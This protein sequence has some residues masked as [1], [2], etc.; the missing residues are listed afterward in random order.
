MEKLERHYDTQARRGLVLTVDEMAAFCRK[1]SIPYSWKDLREMRYRLRYTAFFSEQRRPAQYMGA[2]VEK[3]GQLM[4]DMAFYAPK[5][6][7][8]ASMR[9]AN[10]GF[11]C[12]LV[13]VETLSGKLGAVPCKDSR[14]SS[15]E[16]AI[17]RMLETHFEQVS[18]I[19]SDRDVSVTG[20]AFRARMKRNYGISWTFLRSRSKAYRPERM[21]K[22]LKTRMSLALKASGE[23]RWVDLLPVIV[24]DY[25]SKPIPGTGGI[26]RNSVSKGNYVSML[27]RLYQSEDPGSLNNIA[28]SANY[29]KRVARS[30][31]KF[32][33]G[34]LV[35]LAKSVDYSRKKKGAFDKKSVKGS[36]GSRVYEITG[37]RLKSNGKH[38]LVAVYSVGG[39]SGLYYPGELR[40]A[41]FA[42]RPTPPAAPTASRGRAK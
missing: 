5:G 27:E 31:W 18:V 33:I 11:G 2:S 14:Q 12:F 35:V 6:K 40:K 32:E 19:V 15:W 13:A 20:N 38:F 17:V 24:D 3:F 7:A 1:K 39:L 25:N 21:I 41:L 4:I 36:F 30:L 16:G 34:D 8:G 26:K 10:S 28:N 23:K 29:S 9:R 37:R 42:D 22:Y